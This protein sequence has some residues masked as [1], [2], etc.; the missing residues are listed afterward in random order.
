MNPQRHIEGTAVNIGARTNKQTNLYTSLGFCN[1]QIT[2]LKR[3]PELRWINL[4]QEHD[5]IVPCVKK[6]LNKGGILTIRA[7]C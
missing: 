5:L 6:A 2:W 3:V 4:P 7:P 1:V